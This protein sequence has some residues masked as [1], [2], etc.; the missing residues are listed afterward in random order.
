MTTDKGPLI[1]RVAARADIE[2][3]AQ[4]AYTSYG[5]AVGWTAVSGSPMP[6]W[7]NL[8]EKIQGAWCKAAAAILAYGQMVGGGKLMRSPYINAAVHYVSRGSTDGFYSS[9]CRAATIT[10]IAT[11]AYHG[12]SHPL[13]YEQLMTVGL[14]VM[15]PEGTYHLTLE[16]AGGCK[17]WKPS[18]DTDQPTGGTW[19]WAED[20]TAS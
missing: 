20:C 14:F 10:Q 9:A 1:S 5:E 16:G 12:T 18:D 13:D 8:G 17:H 4:R 15:N 11:P 2:Y 6:Q 3:V 19:H 7:H